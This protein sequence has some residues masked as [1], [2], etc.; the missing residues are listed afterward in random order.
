MSGPSRVSATVP[1]ALDEA[2]ILHLRPYRETSVLVDLFGA[3]SGRL[4]LLAKGARRGGPSGRPT[5]GAFDRILFAAGGRGEL[6][7]LTRWERLSSGAM[8]RG[9]ALFCAYYVA[10]LIMRLVALSDPA[11]DLQGVTCRTL[12][13][14]A[15]GEHAESLLRHFEQVLLSETGYGIN[16]LEDLEGQPVTPDGRYEVDPEQGVLP[17]DGGQ[18]GVPGAALLALASG[19]YPGDR[20]RRHAKHVMRRLLDRRLEGRPLRSRELFRSFHGGE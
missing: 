16:L 18:G 5:L 1:E 3:S 13:G 12:E 4:R 7:L 10:E 8:L 20:E 19:N 14:L 17:L 9:E 11:P 2:L 6:R 15:R